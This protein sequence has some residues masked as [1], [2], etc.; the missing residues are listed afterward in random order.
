[1]LSFFQRDVLDENWDL[2]GS[3]SDGVFYLLYHIDVTCLAG[4]LLP[5]ALKICETTKEV[6]SQI[7][8][9]K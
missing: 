6:K 5:N 4:A 7:A 1:M 3:V 9:Y 2:I 8:I